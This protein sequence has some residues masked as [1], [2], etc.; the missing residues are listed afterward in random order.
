MKTLPQCRVCGVKLS[1]ENWSPSYQHHGNYLCKECKRKQGN[2][3]QSRNLEKVRAMRSRWQKANPEKVKVIKT[4]FNHK[5]GMSSFDENK[6]CAQYLGVHVSERVLS[7]VFK[8][9]ERMPMNNSGYDFICNKG[10][11][12]DVKSSCIGKDGRWAFTIRQNKIAGYFLCI[13]FDNRQNLNPL[14]IWLLPGDK[15]NNFVGVTICPNTAHKWG[16]YQIDI[17]KVV[18]CCETIKKHRE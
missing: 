3:W 18:D 13:A 8:D 5:H 16:E 17:E 9:V 10:M 14:Y 7:N 6:E 12:I 4:R 15:F 2:L 1:N 11:K